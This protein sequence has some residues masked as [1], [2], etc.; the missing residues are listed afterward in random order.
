MVYLVVF[1]YLI[2]TVL[3]TLIGIGRQNEGLKIFLIS[4]LLTPLVAGGYMLFRKKN[5]K[6]IQFYHCSQCEYIFP[7]RI[8]YCP[9]C[10]EKGHRVKLEKYKSPY[11]VTEEIQTTSFA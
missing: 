7:T 4:L 5:Y 1:I 8:K 10:E 3:L 2:V 11:K 9:I 6:R